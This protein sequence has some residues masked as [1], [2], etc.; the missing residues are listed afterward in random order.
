[1]CL[2]ITICVRGM[3]QRNEKGNRFSCVVFAVSYCLP[4]NARRCFSGVV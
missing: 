1:M 2:I 3:R 4:A